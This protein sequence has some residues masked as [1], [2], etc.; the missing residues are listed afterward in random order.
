MLKVEVCPATS[1]PGLSTLQ[2]VRTSDV[3][4]SYDPVT[5]I[6]EFEPSMSVPASVDPVYVAKME[7]SSAGSSA[8]PCSWASLTLPLD[9]S[10][11]AEPLPLAEPIAPRTRM[12]T[13]TMNQV[14]L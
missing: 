6:P 3:P 12:T 14:R 2:P 4:S 5:V 8:A 10:L 11:S 9:G 13:M 1:S 7:V